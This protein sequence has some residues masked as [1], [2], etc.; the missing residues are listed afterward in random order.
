MEKLAIFENDQ[1][2]LEKSGSS[3]TI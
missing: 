1:N 3:G 2:N